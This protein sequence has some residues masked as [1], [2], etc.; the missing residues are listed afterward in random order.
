MNFNPKLI[1]IKLDVTILS[2]AHPTKR[3]G[4]GLFWN[5][6]YDEEIDG[7]YIYRI[8]E[9]DMEKTMRNFVYNELLKMIEEIKEDVENIK[10]KRHYFT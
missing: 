6:Y 5:I 10:L 3:N 8:I 9:L 4:G 7:K 1:V 2:T